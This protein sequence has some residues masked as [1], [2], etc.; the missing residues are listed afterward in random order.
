MP[1]GRPDHGP[2]QVMQVTFVFDDAGDVKAASG[3]ERD[4]A[5]VTFNQWRQG[6]IGNLG[7]RQLVREVIQ[8][9][10]ERLLK[11]DEGE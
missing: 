4:A 5:G 7:G 6:A 10:S 1:I 8:Y 2:V 3:Y 11:I 9:V